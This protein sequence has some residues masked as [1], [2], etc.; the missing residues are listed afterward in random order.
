M[1]T[2][3]GVVEGIPLVDIMLL[4]ANI[5][6]HDF[7]WNDELGKLDD[8]VY[9][10]D[11]YNNLTERFGKKYLWLALFKADALLSDFFPVVDGAHYTYSPT[12]EDIVSTPYPWNTNE[13]SRMDPSVVVPSEAIPYKFLKL[14]I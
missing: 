13:Y 3:N 1:K 11:R 5:A 8:N 4:I 9:S 6:K 7:K 10:E 2:E 14:R 12:N